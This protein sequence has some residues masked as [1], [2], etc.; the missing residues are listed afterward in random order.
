M[1]MR[2]DVVVRPEPG[3]ISPTLHV[4]H[5]L[6]RLGHHVRF[7]CLRP[8]AVQ[9]T[10]DAGLDPI[11][12]FMPTQPAFD[13]PAP[14]RGGPLGAALARRTWSV[15]QDWGDLFAGAGAVLIDQTLPDI[16][17]PA[18]SRRLPVILLSTQLSYARRGTT[19]PLIT[20]AT[21]A[22]PAWASVRADVDR[23]ERDLLALVE[24]G[25]LPPVMHPQFWHR[26]AAELDLGAHL[27]DS[28]LAMLPG[29]HGLA[30]LI[31]VPEQLEL[32]GY[33]RA[34]GLHYLPPPLERVEANQPVLQRRTPHL[35]FCAFGSQLQVYSDAQ[36]HDRAQAVIDA[37][38]TLPDF[39]LALQAP[40]HLRGALRFDDRVEIRPS[41]PQRALL[42]ESSLFFTHC[43]MNSTLEALRAAVPI[44]AQP[45]VRDQLGNAIRLE[46]HDLARCVREWTPASVATIA[47]AALAL[48][49]TRR[50]AAATYFPSRA[51]YDAQLAAL[52][53]AL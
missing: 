23:T 22:A 18:L 48:P 16:V 15:A 43:G 3:H 42:Q 33:H 8:E 14:W 53:P 46:H 1:M 10:A 7:V 31:L 6:Q 27:V 2:I 49:E 32:P 13:A 35:A 50:R 34:A 11:E 21:D 51:S 17:L 41:W 45:L 44:V 19:P 9:L 4:M 39:S 20:L 26:W 38:A 29:W 28:C 36:L 24:S 12:H 25:Q 47:R 40:E 5:A 37:V 30:E 52:F